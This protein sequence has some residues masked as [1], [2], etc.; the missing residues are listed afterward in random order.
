MQLWSDY[1]VIKFSKQVRML[2]LS[3]SLIC[4]IVFA[5]GID[6]QNRWQ[7]RNFNL[8]LHFTNNII[9]AHLFFSSIIASTYLFFLFSLSV[10]I[11][12]HDFV[13][14]IVQTTLRRPVGWPIVAKWIQFRASLLSISSYDQFM[15]SL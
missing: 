3:G 14:N 4:M 2:I 5:N 7:I 15:R 1:E 9:I 11:W 6:Q 8:R 12:H 13:D 10:L